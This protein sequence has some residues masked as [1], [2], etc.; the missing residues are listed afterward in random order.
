[1]STACLLCV[2]QGALYICPLL[3][4]KQRKV[5]APP[6]GPPPA[7]TSTVRV[8]GLGVSHAGGVGDDR[9]SVGTVGEGQP[10]VMV[11]SKQM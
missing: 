7:M 8:S 5:W 1:M 4:P 11:W 9:G 3:P 6:A 10:Q 2:Q